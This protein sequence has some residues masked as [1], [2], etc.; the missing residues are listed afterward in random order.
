VTEHSDEY[1]ATLASPR[2]RRLRAAVIEEQANVCLDCGA[3]TSL[4]ELH[5]LHYRTLGEERMDDVIALC[6]PCHRKADRRRAVQM[7]LLGYS[8]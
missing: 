5:H 6:Q 7:A 3:Y 2:W 8:Y 4:L 1:V